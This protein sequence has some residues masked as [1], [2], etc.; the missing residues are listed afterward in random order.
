LRTTKSD[1]LRIDRTAIREAAKYDGK[2]V[3]VSGDL[4]MYRNWQLKIVP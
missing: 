4:K 1:Q 3:V 2:W